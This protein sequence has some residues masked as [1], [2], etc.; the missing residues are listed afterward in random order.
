M[1]EYVRVTTPN[2]F[3]QTNHR[4]T[5]AVEWMQGW[6]VHWM[7][8]IQY[9]TNCGGV[10]STIS[11]CIS[12]V[13]EVEPKEVTFERITRGSRPFT[14][15][16]EAECSAGGSDWY[17]TGETTVMKVLDDVGPD[18]IE[19]T[20]YSGAVEGYSS[21]IYPNLIRSG[22]IYDNNGRIL[23]QPSGVVVTGGP[24]DVVEGLGLLLDE[25]AAQYSG[26]GVVHIP[27]LLAPAFLAEHL[28]VKNG[29]RLETVEG[30]RV[31]IGHGYDPGVGPNGAAT[32]AGTAY[33]W[34]TSPIFG[35]R[36]PGKILG[37]PASS[38]N[39]ID[40]TVTFIAERTVILGWECALVGV[41]IS[42]GGVVT[43]AVG[44][45]A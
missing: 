4:L 40:N 6:D 24:Y 21:I 15:Y 34:F 35:A 28:L 8:G 13:G 29:N 5:D 19:R 22:P 2:L 20:F 12:G 41:P 44:D 37:N 10:A 32:A 17:T 27:Q 9:D 14:V 43:G 33:I 7:G 31:V 42:T 30:H 45:D 23:I 16:A 3:Q 11:P 26:V 1:G 18:Q 25:G 36:G 38:L 39:R